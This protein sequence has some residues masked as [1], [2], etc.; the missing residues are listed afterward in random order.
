[1][2]PNYKRPVVSTPPTYRAA[3]NA[4]AAAGGSSIGDQGWEQVFREP[5]L[6]DLIRRALANN[7]DLRI[8]AQAIPSA[9]P[10]LRARLRMP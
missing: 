2:G 10:C 9:A 4:D 7:F 3:D 8:A 6:Q 1:M 5:E